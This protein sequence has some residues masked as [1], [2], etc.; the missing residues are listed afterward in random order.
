MKKQLIAITGA[1]A[2]S[3]T[4]FAGAAS[5]KE[6]TIQSGDTLSELAL[7]H[8]TTVSTLQQLNG[9][10]SDLIFAGAQ[11]EVGGNGVVTQA[12]V[13]NTTYQAPVK[14]VQTQT[15]YKAPVQQKQAAPVQKA[16][17]VQQAP[18]KQAPVKKASTSSNYQGSSS[19][20]KSWI[21]MKE[22]TNNYNARS[23]TGKYIGKYQLD[24][25][26]LNGDYSPA[27]Q[28]RVA[29]KYVKERYGSWENAK[30]AWMQKGWY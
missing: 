18:V 7:T 1:L 8:N 30:T 13:Q 11:L 28:E 2:L 4:A 23:A 12:P 15:T 16:A 21:A 25:S 24:R 5:A 10:T 19:S 22:S 14:Q 26:Y 27:N 29:D 17:P 20:A 6:I 3:T 9:L